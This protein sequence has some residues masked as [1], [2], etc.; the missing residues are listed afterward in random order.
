MW[1]IELLINLNNKKNKR[2]WS[3]VKNILIIILKNVFLLNNNFLLILK[4]K[5]KNNPYI[6]QKNIDFIC[7]SNII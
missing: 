6:K 5:L 7:N 2:T 4:V 3:N 1:S